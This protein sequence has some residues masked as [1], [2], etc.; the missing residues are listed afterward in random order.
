M[1]KK[2]ETRQP[3]GHTF[4]L[5][6]KT[7]IAMINESLGKKLL[8]AAL[9]ALLAAHP[10]PGAAQTPTF[11][12]A[13]VMTVEL[14]HAAAQD[15]RE[16]EVPSCVVCHLGQDET[17]TLDF[18][19]VG[20][21]TEALYYSFIHCDAH[22]EPSDLM[23]MEFVEGLN[24]VYGQDRCRAS[25]NTTV[26]YVHYTLSI[27][28]SPLKISGNYMVE[29]RTASDDRLLAREPLWMVED[30]CGLGTRVERDGGAQT[31]D[32][33]VAWP[34]H[35]MA[36]PETEMTVCAWQNKRLDDRRYAEGP[37]FV[38]PDEVMYLRQ[39]ALTFCG[40][41]EW[42]WLD[43]RSI[44]QLGMTDADVEYVGGMYHYTAAPDERPRAYSYHEDFDGGQWIETRDR[45]DDDAQVVADYAM[46]HFTLLPEDPALLSD[47]DV[48][49]IG[50]ATGWEPT[51]ANRLTPDGEAMALR[52]QR[53]VKQGL[54]NYLYAARAKGGRHPAPPQMTETE[55][56][57]G[58]TEN[59]YYVAVYT[60]RPGETY[61]HLAALK[62]HNTLRTIS[63][64]ID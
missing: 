38:R 9:P 58:Q 61:D 19:V 8:N 37:T 28:T 27:D 31:L 63:E 4:P 10:A 43:T 52:G 13:G 22:W 39:E 44:R 32:V 50:D 57:Y 41:T 1:T 12:A 24:K 14:R 2:M 49:V 3:A 62:R 64:F 34:G 35:K 40:G 25:F 42:R 59:D 53:L 6:K 21:N 45:R 54:H 51:S 48:F 33:A 55:G 29:A 60:R 5:A 7:I 11:R 17:L 56:C 26:A 30:R 20:G 18:D 15:R 23:E 47:Y 36:S 16:G 46:A